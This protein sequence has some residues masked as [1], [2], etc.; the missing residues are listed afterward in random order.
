MPLVV[1]GRSGTGKTSLMKP[2]PAQNDALLHV[3][4]R[5]FLTLGLQDVPDS[6][7]ETAL[8]QV[9]L[10]ETIKQTEEGLDYS[11]GVKGSHVSGGQARRLQLAALLLKEPALVLLDEP[12]R[13]LQPDLVQQIIHGIE[14]WL[15]KRFSVIVTHDPSSLPVHWPR[16]PWPAS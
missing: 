11:L 10:L 7:L 4:I 3:S 2:L 14:P 15:L 16:L 12:F 6:R 13:G 9:D 8:Q 1:Y 5:Q